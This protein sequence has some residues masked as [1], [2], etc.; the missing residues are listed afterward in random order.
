MASVV[1]SGDGSKVIATTT[2]TTTTTSDL[3]FF[4]FV[5]VLLGFI[6]GILYIR[7]LVSLVSLD[8]F[9][10]ILLLF[11]GFDFF[12]PLFFLNHKC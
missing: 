2:T 8:V 6:F 4:L 12:I 1:L 10:C 11:I 9:G 3:I 5:S 7:P